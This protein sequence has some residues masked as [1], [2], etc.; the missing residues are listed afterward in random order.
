[1][2]VTGSANSS[3]TVFQGPL[4]GIRL[5]VASASSASVTLRV[6]EGIGW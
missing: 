5:N 1:M 2:S 3:I 4:A 6:L